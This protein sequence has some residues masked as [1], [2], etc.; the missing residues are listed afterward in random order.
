MEL[1][2]ASSQRKYQILRSLAFTSKIL[3]L[4][5]EYVSLMSRSWQPK[6]LSPVVVLEANLKTFLVQTYTIPKGKL[7]IVA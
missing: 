5:L 2:V 7:V 4:I 1:K 6:N 3:V